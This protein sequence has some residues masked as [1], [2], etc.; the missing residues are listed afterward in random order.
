MRALSEL[1]L[2]DKIVNDY[3][4]LQRQNET[5][6]HIFTENLGLNFYKMAL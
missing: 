3:I 1:G 5:F 4:L 6:T 2:E